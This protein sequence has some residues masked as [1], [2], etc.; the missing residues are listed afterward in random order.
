MSK[1]HFLPFDMSD[2]GP[3]PHIVFYEDVQ[4]IMGSAKAV[5]TVIE[6]YDIAGLVKGA[7]KGEGLGINFYLI[8]AKLTR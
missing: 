6:F 1:G 8:S 2:I 3:E 4:R 7:H 5:P